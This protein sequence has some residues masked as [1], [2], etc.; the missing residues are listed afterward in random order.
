MNDRE[1]QE[2]TRRDPES[3]WQRLL[4]FVTKALGSEDDGFNFATGMDFGFAIAIRHPEY[5]VAMRRAIQR[6]GM[7]GSTS[8]EKLVDEFINA[9]PIEEVV[10]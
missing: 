7:T 3:P 9:V 2:Q 6:G 8:T 1:E 4:G 5:A 10:G